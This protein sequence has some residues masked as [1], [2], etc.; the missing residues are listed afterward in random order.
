MVSDRKSNTA[1]TGFSLRRIYL[2][3][4]FVYFAL[5]ERAGGMTIGVDLNPDKD[6]D[7]SRIYG[8][9][10]PS[11]QLVQPQLDVEEMARELTR[12][13]TLV[14]SGH[15]REL[16]PYHLVP[17]Q[18]L[19]LRH[20]A[21]GGEREPTLAPEFPEAIQAVIHVRALSGPP[22]TKLV[23]ITNGT[24]L[25]LPG[26]QQSLRHLTRSDE[27][28]V[29][30]DGGTQAYVNKVNPSTLPLDKILSNILL[31]GRERPVVIQSMFPAINDVGPALDEV[32][33][34]GRRLLEL[35]H[36]GAQIS[37]VQIYS[38]TSP[39]VGAQY[40][41]LPLNDLS[42]IGQTVRQISGLKAEIF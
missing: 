36:A 11:G 6:S 35:K 14:R 28:W 29:E 23:L 21:L 27:V 10:H 32:E 31:L 33:Q 42:R 24:G 26:V 4:R 30:L 1:G 41:H 15:L 38:A 2:N 19:E 9:A 18:F 39:L 25:D 16:P 5:S 20:V 34:F 3:N 7:P 40:G 37:R 12:A 13:L 17:D 8:D 22:F